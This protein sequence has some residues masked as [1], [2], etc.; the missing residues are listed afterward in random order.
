MLNKVRDH[1]QHT[2][3]HRYHRYGDSGPVTYF[4]FENHRFH[5]EFLLSIGNFAVMLQD[6][7]RMDSISPL[8][9]E[10]LRPPKL[11]SMGL[12]VNLN[13][14]PQPFLPDSKARKWHYWLRNCREEMSSPGCLCS[15]EW[16]GYYTTG[17]KPMSPEG[18]V[19]AKR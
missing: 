12:S 8:N 2:D 14:I 4:P 9:G 17:T 18:Q 5:H 6:K 19:E 15:G 11:M 16:V 1:Q 7:I 10:I 13:S 3:W